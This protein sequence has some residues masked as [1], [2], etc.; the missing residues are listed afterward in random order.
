M[1]P[2]GPTL[3]TRSWRRRLRNQEQGRGR[4]RAQD[5]APLVLD[6]E[7]HHGFPAAPG[8]AHRDQAAVGRGLVG[9]GLDVVALRHQP[10]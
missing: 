1:R 2:S 10:G 7:T 4:L 5:P 8:V 3:R 6:E 9:I